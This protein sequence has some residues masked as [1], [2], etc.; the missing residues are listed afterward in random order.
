LLAVAAGV[1]G[2][3][4]GVLLGFLAAMLAI[5][6][7][8][9]RVMGPAG[10]GTVEAEHSFLHLR[11][12]RRRAKLLRQPGATLE[13]LPEDRGWVATAHRRLVGVQTI[14]IDSIVGTVDGH[15]AAAF[16]RAFRPPDYS[17]G[18]WTLMFRAVRRGMRMPPISVYRVDGRHYVRDGHHRVSVAKATGAQDIDAEVVELRPA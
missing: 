3:V 15:K 2:G 12:Q 9:D 10:L 4:L 1:T 6:R 8:L 18:R 16:D 11:G 5:D 17:R 14:P 7:L 13:Y